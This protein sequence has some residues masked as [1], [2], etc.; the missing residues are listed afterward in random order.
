MDQSFITGQIPSAIAVDANYIYFSQ[1]Y[2]SQFFDTQISRA[3]LDGTGVNNTFIPHGPF[4]IN[5]MAV[6]SGHLYWSNGFNLPGSQHTIGRA[7]LDGTGA[8]ESF[9]T[10]NGEAWELAVDSNHIYWAVNLIP[11]VTFSGIGRANLDG[12]GINNSFIAGLF[13][14][15]GVALGTS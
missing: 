7:N 9:I 4:N 6:D 11:F 5:G 8:N 10:S 3:N 14:P 13:H 15:L 12:T 2:N 1:N